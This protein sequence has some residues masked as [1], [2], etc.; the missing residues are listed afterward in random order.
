MPLHQPSTQAGY[1]Q[2]K[3]LIW[4]EGGLVTPTWTGVF[5]T[6]WK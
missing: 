4:A 5:D 1:P 3:A 2:G 6:D